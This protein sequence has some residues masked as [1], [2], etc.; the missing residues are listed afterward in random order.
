MP[1]RSSSLE[2]RAVDR[3]PVPSAVT[4]ARDDW[5]TP[6]GLFQAYHRIYGFTIDVAANSANA[7]C[8]NYFDKEAD[9]L[10]QR[11]RGHVVWCHPPHSDPGPW[12]H[13]ARI[14][15]T[16]NRVTVVALVPA[17][18]SADWWHRDVMPFASVRFLQGVPQFRLQRVL[19]TEKIQRRLPQT[20]FAVVVFKPGRTC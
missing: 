19:V 11:W 4:Y 3:A 7:C 8:Q 13:K 9:G 14:E 15:A 12:M 1:M 18:T 17:L 5:E 16:G 10:R 2:P 6:A 20:P